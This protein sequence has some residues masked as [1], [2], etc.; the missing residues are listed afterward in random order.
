MK[1]TTLAVFFTLF[2][3]A[4]LA[5][6]QNE[7][8]STPRIIQANG[9]AL[10]SLLVRVGCPPQW[11]SVAMNQVRFTP[12]DLIDELSKDR[13]FDITDCKNPTPAEAMQTELYLAEKEKD[14]L[15]YRRG[16]FYHAQAVNAKAELASVKIALGAQIRDLSNERDTFQSK[17]EA[18]EFELTSPQGKLSKQTEIAA[19]AAAKLHV[20][21]NLLWV[22]VPSA[23]VFLAVLVPVSILFLGA[24]KQLM[25]ARNDL[26]NLL[27]KTS[28][29]IPESASLKEELSAAQAEIAALALSLNN[30]RDPLGM[31][32]EGR[33][34]FTPMREIVVMTSDGEKRFPFVGLHPKP[35]KPEITQL[36]YACPDN[37]KRHCMPLVVDSGEEEGAKQRAISHY[38]RMHASKTTDGAQALAALPSIV[39]RNDVQRPGD[40]G[41]QINERFVRQS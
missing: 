39:S 10:E 27:R 24:Q 29:P 5:M 22:F 21:N 41:V 20:A 15:L 37:T 13:I 25:R 9:P 17:A 40:P 4:V 28:E 36:E 8:T 26:A 14:L 35:Q 2:F 23:I 33:L 30:E 12:A 32:K 6:A 11:L 7:Q 1:P 16:A 3:G 18:G 34:F 38:E 19:A 31:F